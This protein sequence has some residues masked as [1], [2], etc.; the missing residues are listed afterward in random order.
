MS[1]RI[2]VATATY[3]QEQK[4]AAQCVSQYS[5]PYL[6]FDE[7]GTNAHF[8]FS[9]MDSN[10][11]LIAGTLQELPMTASSQQ[12]PVVPPVYLG[13]A[14]RAYQIQLMKLNVNQVNDDNTIVVVPNSQLTTEQKEAIIGPG[15]S[16]PMDTSG[17]Y[18]ANAQNMMQYVPRKPMFTGKTLTGSTWNPDTREISFTA[19][20]LLSSVYYYGCPQGTVTDTAT[21]NAIAP[22]GGMA[23]TIQGPRCFQYFC[24]DQA[25]LE[26][27]ASQNSGC[28]L[29]NDG[30]F[31]ASP[32]S[33]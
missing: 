1:D 17:A 6:K 11:Y 12:L 26:S 4:I 20:N 13:S 32:S 30:T 22:V 28:G 25:V 29:T 19:S 14:G 33:N 7:P 9:F 8:E 18:I 24:D 21:C 15:P 5:Q 3:G 31:S 2:D 10:I 27:N 16:Y 23:D